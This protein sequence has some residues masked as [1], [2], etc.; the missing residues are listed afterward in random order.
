MDDGMVEAADSEVASPL[1]PSRPMRPLADLLRDPIPLSPNLQ[2]RFYRGGRVLS[3]FRGDRNGGDG[4]RPEDWVGSATRAWTP[5][6]APPTDDGLSTVELDDRRLTLAAILD[7]EPEA[8]VG[9]AML[10]RLGPSLGVL[11]KL[12]DAA[13]RLPVHCHPTRPAAARLL[14]SPFGKTEAWLILATRGPATIWAGF[15]DDPTRERL[16][17]WI[18]RQDIDAIL[19][20][21]VPH[22]VAAGDAFVIPAGTPHAI[23]A[24]IF[25]LEVQEPTDYSVVA[26][27]RGFPVDPMAAALDLGWD[28]TIEFFDLAASRSLRAKPEPIGDGATSLFGSSA[29]AFFRAVRMVVDDERPVP[30]ERAYAVAVVLDGVGEALGRRRRLRLGRGTTF[31]VPAAAMDGLRIAGDGLELVLCLPPD[32]TA[33]DASPLPT[34]AMR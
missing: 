11:V 30:V 9:R 34:P 7:A 20:A 31:A 3:A 4:D 14:G 15:R 32:P 16:R 33:L 24:G 29:D 1:L 10:D 13:Q 25:L 2:Q 26:E 18:D 21:L 19:G 12:L 5:A 27:W 8:L 22:Q 6:G 23:G 28:R 17:A